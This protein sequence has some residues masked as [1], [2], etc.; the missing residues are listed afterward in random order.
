MS[1]KAA[2]VSLHSCGNSAL[3]LL[4]GTCN[5]CRWGSSPQMRWCVD[6]DLMAYS[7]VPEGV[8]VQHYVSWATLFRVLQLVQMGDQP[9][10]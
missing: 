2:V 1:V 6:G 4:G 9:L 5:W 8:A 10:R 7:A 3:C